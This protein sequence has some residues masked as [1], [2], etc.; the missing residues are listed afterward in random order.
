MK[1]R[2]KEINIISTVIPFLAQV[3]RTLPC[4]V[5]VTP[6]LERT[7]VVTQHRIKCEK[8]A[9][10]ANCCSVPGW[11]DHITHHIN[12][13]AQIT[14]HILFEAAVSKAARDSKLS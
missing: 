6:R 14:L 5:S 2:K 8:C 4:R 12:I 7:Q 10:R 11:D 1:N 13:P 9:D 3:A